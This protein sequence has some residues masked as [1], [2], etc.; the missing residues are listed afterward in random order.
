MIL[1]CSSESFGIACS[2]VKQASYSTLSMM[3][4]PLPTVSSVIATSPRGMQNLHQH[5]NFLVL[6][7]SFRWNFSCSVE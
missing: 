1:A 3:M 5:S 7:S 4:G 6:E 2:F